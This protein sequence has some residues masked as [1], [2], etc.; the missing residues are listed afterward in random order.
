VAPLPSTSRERFGFIGLGKFLS[1]KSGQSPPAPTF[2]GRVMTP[3]ELAAELLEDF[4][5]DFI[6]EET[7][8]K[9]NDGPNVALASM[10]AAALA[11]CIAGGK[12]A[13]ES[14]RAPLVPLGQMA[15]LL[16]VKGAWLRGEAEAG[17]LP[18]L[19]AGDTILFNPDLVEQLLFERASAR[20]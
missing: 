14:S 6:N 17:R 19:P 2:E 20:L 3:K 8:L 10:I 4:D 11:G 1:Q 7:S 5:V 13:G 12:L 9:Y 16:G 15:R 18:H